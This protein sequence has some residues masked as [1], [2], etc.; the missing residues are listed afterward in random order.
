MHEFKVRFHRTSQQ[1]PTNT[2]KG[3]MKYRSG[4]KKY[5]RQKEA[6]RAT[7]VVPQ[8]ENNNYDDTLSKKLSY[9]RYALVRGHYAVQGNSQ[10]LILVPIERSCD[11]SQRRNHYRDEVRGLE[12]HL[13]LNN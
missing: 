2:N 12:K 4:H 1:T 9:R 6:T 5:C 13:K 8:S 10:S 11:C 3:S 7:S